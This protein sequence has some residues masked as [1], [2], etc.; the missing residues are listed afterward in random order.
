MIIK[1]AEVGI[2]KPCSTLDLVNLHQ[3]H[4][5]TPEKDTSLSLVRVN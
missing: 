2:N 3:F 5:T 4:I 1:G